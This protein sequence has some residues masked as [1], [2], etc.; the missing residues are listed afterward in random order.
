MFR[1]EALMY[2]DIVPKINQVAGKFGL[3]GV[4]APRSYYANSEEGFLVMEDLKEQG[5]VIMDKAKG[6]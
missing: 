6:K 5:Y 1:T 3:E 4:P 2:T